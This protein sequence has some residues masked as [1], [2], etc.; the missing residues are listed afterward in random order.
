MIERAKRQ[1]DDGFIYNITPQK[2]WQT[3]VVTD[4]PKTTVATLGYSGPFVIDE[5]EQTTTAFRACC[6]FLR[7]G[8]GARI[9]SK[10]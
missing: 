10:D 5:P 2:V 3:R 4:H 7:E 8:N 1:I 6:D 9:G